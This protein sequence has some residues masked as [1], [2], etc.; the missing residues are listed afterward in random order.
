M[1]ERCPLLEENSNPRGSEWLWSTIGVR[2][3]L[4][5]LARSARPATQEAALGALQNITAGSGAVRGGEGGLVR[6]FQDRERRRG[7]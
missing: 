7:R 2:M 3:Y 6:R 5:L 4:S 1:E